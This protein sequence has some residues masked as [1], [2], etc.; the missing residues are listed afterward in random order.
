MMKKR[1]ISILWIVLFAF[2]ACSTNSEEEEM[3]QVLEEIIDPALVG[4]WSGE[5]SGSFG[6][7]TATFILKSDGKT[8]LTVEEGSSNYC[9]IPNLRWYVLGT[10]FKMQGNDQCHGTL[11]NFNA[12]YS[13]TKL[14]GNWS[15]SSGNSGSFT[16][17]KQ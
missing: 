8:D 9:P 17:T 15:A 14:V 16:L 10:N 1:N 11:V 7:A 2:M 3:Q 4:T 5:I 6:D 13:K 12:P